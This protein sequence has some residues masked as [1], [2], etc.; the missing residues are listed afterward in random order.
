M[1]KELATVQPAEA[2]PTTPAAEAARL[3][4]P[5]W[6]LAFVGI[7]GY[8]IVEYMRLPMSYEIFRTIYIGKVVILVAALGWVLSPRLRGGDRSMPRALDI[9]VGLL[10]LGVFFSMLF[11]TYLDL[12]WDAYL[13]L[14]KWGVIYF[15]IARIVISSWRVKIFVFLLLLLNLKL[16]QAGIR[17]FYNSRAYWG[18]EMVAV[19]EGARAGSTGFFSNSAD[20]GVAMC[21]VWPIATM[22]LFSRPKGLWRFLLLACVPVLLLAILVCG[23]RGAVVGAIC[24]LLVAWV[25]TVRKSAA[26]LMVILFLPGIFFV[27]PEAS[28]ERFRSA[29]NYQQDPTASS[30]IIFWKAGLKMFRDHPLM[31]VGLANF[32]NVRVAEY[33]DDEGPARAYVPHSIYIQALS[34]LGILGTAPFVGLWILSFVTNSRTRKRL[35]GEDPTN[36][37]SF[38][39]CLA[40]GLDLAMVGYLASGAFVAVLYYPHLW[41]LLGLSSGLHT[42]CSRRRPGQEYG[43]PTAT[44]PSWRPAPA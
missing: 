15:L 24:I 34:E 14:L 19:R 39:F 13:D 18:D 42:A 38:E 33:L 43:P 21:V 29:I 44:D 11:A 40:C 7:L 31:G 10:L 25:R 1:V 8:V 30:R 26:F 3:T 9:M 22:L 28:K 4:E 16:A 27:L 37:R 32:A 41:V 20:Y 36:R 2:P 5:R 17:Y 35:L 6:S 23:S 12:A